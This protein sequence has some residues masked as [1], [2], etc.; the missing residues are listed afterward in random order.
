MRVESSGR[1]FVRVKVQ[2]G[3]VFLT[4]EVPLYLMSSS[5][6]PSNCRVLGGISTRPILGS[7]CRVLGGGSFQ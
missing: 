1:L 3:C 5:P 4:N 7:Y 2:A 6:D